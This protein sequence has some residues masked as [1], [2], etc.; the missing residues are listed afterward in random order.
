[1]EVV[2]CEGIKLAGSLRPRGNLKRQEWRSG[3]K[4]KIAYLGPSQVRQLW[5]PGR[6]LSCGL[7]H[8]GIRIG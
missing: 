4:M 7:S 2:C 8:N 5:I 1:M 3:R 6:V